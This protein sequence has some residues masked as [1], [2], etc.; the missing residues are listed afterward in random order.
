MTG[1]QLGSR[2][3]TDIAFTRDRP[4]YYQNILRR[5]VSEMDR[6]RLKQA[7]AIVAKFPL[8]IEEQRGLSIAD[9]S[10]RSRKWRDVFVRDGGSLDVVF[11]DHMLLVKPSSRYSGNRVREV[12]EI[13][14]GL[15]SLAKELECAVVALCQ[16]NRGVEG[17]DE[18]RP[19]L[20]DLRDS[21]AIEEDASNVI[22]IYRPAYYLE[23]MK[24][25]KPDAAAALAE[26]L[27]AKR[28]LLEFIIAKNRNGSP[29]IVEAFVDIGAN[30]V[31]NK[32]FG[33]R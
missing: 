29:G 1:K 5:D 3:L 2:L 6:N 25:D 18:K 7:E 19:M 13:S 20:S 14:D 31:R 22:F 28:T 9:I 26:A 8:R 4:I 30:A 27:A 32:S 12:A 17:R 15:A 21:G 11:V 24:S 16:L 33:V 10:A 23:R